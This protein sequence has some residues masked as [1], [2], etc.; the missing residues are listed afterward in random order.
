[1]VRTRPAHSILAHTDSPTGCQSL[2]VSANVA[3]NLRS[4][5]SRCSSK[6][7]PVRTSHRMRC[8]LGGILACIDS[9]QMCLE[10]L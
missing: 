10:G 7:R 8:P 1:M 6:P 5:L 2:G 3:D 4:H 9:P